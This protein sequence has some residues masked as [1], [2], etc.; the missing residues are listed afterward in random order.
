MKKW[1]TTNVEG[2]DEG[3]LKVYTTI[4]PFQYFTERIGGEH[5]AE[6]QDSFTRERH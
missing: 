1:G 2:N 5:V 4:Y 6:S 3:E